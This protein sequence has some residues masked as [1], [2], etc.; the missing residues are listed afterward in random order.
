MG[1]KIVEITLVS[2]YIAKRVPRLHNFNFTFFVKNAFFPSQNS[3]DV[4]SYR[5]NKISLE[6]VLKQ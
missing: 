6:I 2:C 5:L 4:R 1:N 3:L